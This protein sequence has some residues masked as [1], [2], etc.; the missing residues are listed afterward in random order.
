MENLWRG[1]RVSLCCN[2]NPSS[3]RA[4]NSCLERLVPIFAGHMLGTTCQSSTYSFV[5]PLTQRLMPS[6][7]NQNLYFILL[8]ERYSFFNPLY[9]GVGMPFLPF[10]TLALHK[11]PILACIAQHLLAKLDGNI[12]ICQ[13]KEGQLVSNNNVVFATP[14]SVDFK[15]SSMHVFFNPS[16]R[17]RN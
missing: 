16:V 5:L 3:S 14:C 6:G 2:W 12:V 8:V 17:A 1:E 10:L 4:N 15:D 7:Q 9:V 11:V 13:W